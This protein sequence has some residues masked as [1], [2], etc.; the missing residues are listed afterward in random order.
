VAPYILHGALGSPYSLKV[1]AA[2]RAKRVPHVWTALN[3]A[4]RAELMSRVRVPVIPVIQRPDG[5][6]TNDST[7]FLLE[8]E[9]AGEGR[10]LLPEAPAQ[11][12]ACRLIE[13]MADEWVTKAMFHFRWSRAADAEQLSA[14]LIYD[15]MPTADRSTIESFAAAF[16]KRQIDRMP[17]VGCTEDTAP[18]IEASAR[19]LLRI[20]DDAATGEPHFLFGGRASLADVALYGQLWQLRTDPTPAAM[21]RADFPY[22]FRWLEHVDD[23]AGHDGEWASEP[24]PAVTELL[25]MAGDTYL[26]FLAAN[27]AAL[28][29]GDETF[30][31]AIEGGEFSQNTFKYQARCL[32]AL[33]EAWEQVAAHQKQQQAVAKQ[34]KKPAAGLVDVSARPIYS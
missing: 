27:E 34:P 19:R 28:A 2:L 22:A 6:W 26:P 33:R 21:M 17:I 25:A 11:R 13:D 5:S 15:T 8:L 3:A 20:L 30:S 9:A 4:T 29:A 24:G 10:A 12:F 7:P 18:I 31:V 23:A 1:R 14:W 32:G 16:A